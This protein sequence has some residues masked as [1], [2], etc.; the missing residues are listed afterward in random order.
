MKLVSDAHTE[1]K[2]KS[3]RAKA[4]RFDMGFR[5]QYPLLVKYVDG[6]QPIENCSSTYYQEKVRKHLQLIE[7]MHRQADR[8]E[9]LSWRKKPPSPGGSPV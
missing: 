5:R 9:A 4:D 2:I 8:L 7:Q 3:I 1:K 6:I